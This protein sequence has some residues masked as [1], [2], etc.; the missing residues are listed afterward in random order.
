MVRRSQL[1]QR[2]ANPLPAAVLIAEDRP[3]V[4]Q[5]KYSTAVKPKVSHIPIESSL[6]KSNNSITRIS[7]KKAIKP[8]VRTGEP[9]CIRQV[10]EP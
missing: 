8:K 5:E 6:E 7:T 4:E 2:L 3:V 10:T 9:T 1:P